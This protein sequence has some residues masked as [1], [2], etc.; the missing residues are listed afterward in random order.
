MSKTVLMTTKLV[1]EELWKVLHLPEGT[2]V[3]I[4]SLSLAR[5]MN[6]QIFSPGLF[7]GISRH[8]ETHKICYLRNF[9]GAFQNWVE[10]MSKKISL[11]I[12][13]NK[14]NLEKHKLFWI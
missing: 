10:T 6:F 14:W 7:P 3:I 9:A 2:K 8:Q 5:S 12:W 1:P 4:Y 11:F 13:K